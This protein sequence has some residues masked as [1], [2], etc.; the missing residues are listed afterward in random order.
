MKQVFYGDIEVN[1]TDR[2][3]ARLQEIKTDHFNDPTWTP[4]KYR[5]LDRVQVNFRMSPILFARIKQVAQE[6]DMTTSALCRIIMEA[7]AS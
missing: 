5:G 7:V 2:E 3:Y 1:F 6:K 4:P